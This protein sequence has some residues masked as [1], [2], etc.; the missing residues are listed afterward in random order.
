MNAHQLKQQPIPDDALVLIDSGRY[1]EQAFVDLTYVIEHPGGALTYAD[2]KTPV[3]EGATP[4]R[5]VVFS[6]P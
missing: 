4:R 2:L 5:A 6:R 1:L 3:P